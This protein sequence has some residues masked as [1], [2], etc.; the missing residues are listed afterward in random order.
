MLWAALRARRGR[1]LS[2]DTWTPSDQCTATWLPRGAVFWRRHGLDVAVSGGRIDLLTVCAC[3]WEALAARWRSLT[4]SHA[5]GH[6][7]QAFLACSCSTRGG[8]YAISDGRG[9]PVAA[10]AGGTPDAVRGFYATGVV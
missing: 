4:C 10:P 8:A 1:G 7:Q 9:A 6:A 5:A 3:C 2:T